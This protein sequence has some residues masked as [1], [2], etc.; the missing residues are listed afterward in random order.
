MV[1][2]GPTQ[3]QRPKISPKVV[4]HSKIEF[5]DG[6]FLVEGDRSSLEEDDS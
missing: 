6:K 2:K 5:K 4:K 1:A 3:A